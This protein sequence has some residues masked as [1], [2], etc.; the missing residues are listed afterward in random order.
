M[1]R[2][3]IENNY[4]SI[5]KTLAELKMPVG[6]LIIALVRNDDV[7]IPGGK[8]IIQS[9]DVLYVNMKKDLYD[10]VKLILTDTVKEDSH[11]MP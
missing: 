9:G 6:S 8:D 7:L 11:E 4:I 2:F 5:G 10:K 3:V 1:F